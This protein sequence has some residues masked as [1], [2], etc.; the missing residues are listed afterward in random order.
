MVSPLNISQMTALGSRY[1]FFGVRVGNYL[2]GATSTTLAN[3][4]TAGMLRVNGVQN[5]A[6]TRPA[7]STVTVA[8]DNGKIG[9]YSIA[10]TDS[11]TG[12]LGTAVFD[13]NF[14]TVMTKRT[15]KVSGGF[16][17]TPLSNQCL[18]YE[19]LVFVINTPAQ[20]N[21]SGTKGQAGYLVTEL[22]SVQA[23]PTGQT[24]GLNTSVVFEYTLSL[25]ES[26]RD[27]FGTTL[28]GYNANSVFG[29]QY[30]SPKP[31]HYAVYVGDGT[32]GQAT[33]T[34]D[35]D[36]A[37]ASADAVQVAINGT[38]QTYSTHFTAN[39]TTNK[40]SFVGTIPA[41]GE[42]AVIRYMFNPKC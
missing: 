38:A 40:V 14:E 5:F 6:M 11:V 10:P 3:G 17:M 39:L 2:N 7:L 19:N 34:L 15:L 24:F 12:T 9:Q 31:I 36:I 16:D 42:I 41:S 33:A 18:S 29:V 22:Y 21:E 35:Y 13:M 25:N 1:T 26:D 28:S 4:V 37:E 23:Q 8:G 27:L 32:S 20:S 30:F